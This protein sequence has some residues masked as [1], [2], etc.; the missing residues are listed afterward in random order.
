MARSTMQCLLLSSI[1]LFTSGDSQNYDLLGEGE[2]R[3][4][5]GAYPLKY[6]KGYGDLTP[7]NNSDNAEQATQDCED[8][9]AQYRWCYAAE[10]V[11]RDVWPTPECRLVTDRPTFES[12]YGSNHDYSWGAQTIIDDVSYQTYCNGG[13]PECASDNDFGSNWDGGVLYPRTGY[14]C[15]LNNEASNT[16]CASPD[17]LGEG[18]CRQSDGAYPL[19]YSKGYGD[20][21]PWNISDNAEQATQDCKQTCDQYSWCYAAEVVLRDVW[22]TPECRLVTDRPTFENVYGSDQD[23]SWGTQKSM[24]DVANI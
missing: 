9:C 5:D 15:Y 7:W 24:D 8:T 6:S 23:Y 13:N 14:W 12:C 20:L 3:Q 21:T 22:D 17:L 16:G 2:C 4:S 19:K 1:H 10:V 18:E 11:L